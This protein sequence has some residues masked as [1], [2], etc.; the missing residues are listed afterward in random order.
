[1]GRGNKCGVLK[2]ESTK[3]DEAVMVVRQLEGLISSGLIFAL[4]LFQLSSF[5]VFVGF[6][7]FVYCGCS[8]TQ[9]KETN[10]TVSPHVLIFIWFPRRFDHEPF[11]LLSS[12]LANTGRFTGQGRMERGAGFATLAITPLQKKKKNDVRGKNRRHARNSENGR[13]SKNKSFRAKVNAE[14]SLDFFLC[15]FHLLWS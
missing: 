8:L 5:F 14:N 6:C 3:D 12:S 13:K 9:Y 10:P 4:N 1:V 2:R 7:V 15:Y 11:S